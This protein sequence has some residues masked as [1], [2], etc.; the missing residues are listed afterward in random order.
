MKNRDQSFSLPKRAR[1][2]TVADRRRVIEQ[3]GLGRDLSDA[4]LAHLAENSVALDFGRR[5]FIYRAGDPADSLFAIAAG[6]IKLCRIE[7]GTGRKP[8]L[9]F[10]RPARSSASP[11]FIQLPVSVKTSPSLTS[12]HES[13]EFLPGSF[14]W[15]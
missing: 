10:S 1:D 7:Q 3:L 11:H 12:N 5:R 15:G 4:A 13:C 6:R 2:M 8:Q 14:N 9:T